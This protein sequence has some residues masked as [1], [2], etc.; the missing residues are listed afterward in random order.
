MLWW[1]WWS[2]WWWSW[3]RWW[4]Y[5]S[6]CVAKRV[7][8]TMVC[9]QKRIDWLGVKNQ[10]YL[11]IYHS[12]KIRIVSH[13]RLKDIRWGCALTQ[14]RVKLQK[15]GGVFFWLNVRWVFCVSSFIFF[16][17]MVMLHDS[18]DSLEACRR[19]SHQRKAFFVSVGLLGGGWLCHA[20]MSSM[21]WGSSL[22]L[23]SGINRRRTTTRK[24]RLPMMAPGA[25]MAISDW[26][27]QKQNRVW[28]YLIQFF[29]LG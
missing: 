28:T 29:P 11:S 3:W 26:K 10:I 13:I 20:L 19:S 22:P 17:C 5:G 15:W 16:C 27:N 7:R 2:R 8:L 24:Q 1:W 25:Q 9:N 4:W 6:D 21:V 14:L 12:L 23:V 18:E